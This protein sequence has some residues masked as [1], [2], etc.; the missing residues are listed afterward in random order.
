MKLS[1]LKLDKSNY[2]PAAGTAAFTKS[3]DE[4]SSSDGYELEQ[5]GEVVLVTHSGRTAMFGLGKVAYGLVE[6]PAAPPV[7]VAQKG[8]RR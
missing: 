2:D 4:Y 1:Y 7:Q 5:R 3:R 8:P 6:K